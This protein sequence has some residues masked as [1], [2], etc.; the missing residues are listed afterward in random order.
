[1]ICRLF[2]KWSF[3][4]SSHLEICHILVFFLF[5]FFEVENKERQKESRQLIQLKKYLIFK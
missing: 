5:P 4:W 3:S 2:H 1:M